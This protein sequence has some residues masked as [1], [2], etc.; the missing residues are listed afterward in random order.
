MGNKNNPVWIVAGPTASGKSALAARLAQRFDGVVI[1]ADSMQIYHEIPVISAQPS[2]EEYALAPHRLYGFHPITEPCSAVEWA[3]HALREIR[4]AFASN[5][6]P[7]LVG[8]SG[9]YLKALTEGMS[10]MPEVPDETRRD[11]CELY[12]RIGAVAFHQKLVEIDPMTAQRLHPTDR[13]RCIRALE[14]FTASNLPLSHWQALAK[15][16]PD[17]DLGFKSFI[18]LPPR[19]WLHERIDRRFIHMTQNG[20][21]EEAAAINVLNPDPMLTGT[22]AVGLQP[23]RDYLQG[24]IP[25][26]AAIEQGQTQSR[27]YAK[28]QYTWFRN[29]NLPDK[30]VSHARDDALVLEAF[31]HFA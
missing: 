21:V 27:Q 10:P 5:L 6:Q 3:H 31:A 26:D 7:I 11:I 12:D 9:M 30:A 22:R 19:D 24:L 2:R 1:N 20:A 8:G 17:P 28:R 15:Q 13:Q 16:P 29:Q 23:L 4:M 14:I 18:L 25:L